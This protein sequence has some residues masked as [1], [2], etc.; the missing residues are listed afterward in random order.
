[1]FAAQVCS[2]SLVLFKRADPT[3]TGRTLEKRTDPYFH[4][5][6]YG[7]NEDGDSKRELLEDAIKDVY[8]LVSI[9]L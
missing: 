2:R 3:F 4:D 8:E 9:A 5:G 7:R 6:D 1:M